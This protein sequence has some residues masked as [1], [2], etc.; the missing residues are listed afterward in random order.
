[1]YINN[2]KLQN[3]LYS[4][5][6]TQLLVDV[7]KPNY[8]HMVVERVKNKLHTEPLTKKNKLYQSVKY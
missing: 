7:K 8:K 4:R 6:K 3:N 5:V 2:I 1:M